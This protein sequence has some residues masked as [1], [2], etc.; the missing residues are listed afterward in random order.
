MLSRSGAARAKNAFDQKSAA[1]AGAPLEEAGVWIV[2]CG[3]D[4]KQCYQNLQAAHDNATPGDV[5]Q[6]ENGTYAGSPQGSETMLTIGKNLTLRAQHPRQVVL[7]GQ[8]VRRV[9]NASG[10]IAV[11]LE[12]L[13]IVNGYVAW[14]GKG[15]GI[16][17][18]AKLVMTGCTMRDNYAV[19]LPREGSRSRAAWPTVRLS[20]PSRCSRLPCSHL[21]CRTCRRRRSM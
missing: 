19:R 3:N 6:L 12:D 10:S 14:P 18:E 9:L 16:Y 8:Q 1:A 5:L 15:G 20:A 7:D 21:A 17:S 2:K 11:Q 4:P 13:D